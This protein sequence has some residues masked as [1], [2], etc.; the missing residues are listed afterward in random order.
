MLCVT[1]I[2]ENKNDSINLILQHGRVFHNN[3]CV[4]FPSSRFPHLI[5]CSRQYKCKVATTFLGIRAKNN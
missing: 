2:T 3:C 1:R 4:V 5:L